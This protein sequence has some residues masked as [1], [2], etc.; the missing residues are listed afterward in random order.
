[1]GEDFGRLRV[2][3]SPRPTSA[4]LVAILQYTVYCLILINSGSYSTS[5]EPESLWN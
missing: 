3:E 2:K 5:I 1:M 4:M